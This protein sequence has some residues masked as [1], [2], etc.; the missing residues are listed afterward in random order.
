MSP[1]RAGGFLWLGLLLYLVG[2]LS[3]A[4]WAG[5][6]TETLTA[7]TREQVTMSDGWK[8]ARYWTAE[9]ET[10][11][12]KYRLYPGD[13]VYFEIPVRW[14]TRT[15]REMRRLGTE[16]DK[17]EADV[18]LSANDRYWRAMMRMFDAVDRKQPKR[19]EFIHQAI[20]PAY[21]ILEHAVDR[22]ERAYN[23]SAY[24]ALAEL[25]RT[26]ALVV[27]LTP[28]IGI[29]GL[30]VLGAF[31]FVLRG[32]QRRAESVIRFEMSQLEREASYDKLTGVGNHG[33]FHKACRAEVEGAVAGATALKLALVDVDDFKLV[34]DQRGH[35][36]GDSVLR[37][38]GVL[39]QTQ[40]P[41]LAYRI[42]GDEFAILLP[43]IPDEDAFA[44]L[45]RLRRGAESALGRV[46][47]SIGLSKLTAL[48]SEFET[49]FEQADAALYDAKHRG[50]N[51]VATRLVLFGT[52]VSPSAALR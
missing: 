16:R 35:R 3:L 31:F 46:T 50:R 10:L 26:Q 14:L 52:D 2:L 9:E 23:R 42:G 39:L 19:V 32:Y 17:R 38:I 6:R 5:V 49:L 20:D 4:V 7:Y 24:R 30:T 22:E 8:Q 33:A 15:V 40:F 1:Y 36:H 12:R 51:V 21:D 47:L 11:E 25:D 41:D 18:I 37:A 13:R 28:V 45:E 34:N 43:L 29:I 44:R 27:R 48:T